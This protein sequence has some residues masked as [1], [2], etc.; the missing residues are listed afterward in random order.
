MFIFG[1]ETEFT[2]YIIK[3]QNE[4]KIKEGNVDLKDKKII[5]TEFDYGTYSN[6]KKNKNSR[7]LSDLVLL[8]NNTI[9]FAE[10]K[11]GRITNEILQLAKQSIKNKFYYKEIKVIL[12]GTLISKKV[13]EEIIETKYLKYIIIDDAEYRHGYKSDIEITNFRYKKNIEAI[14]YTRINKIPFIENN[15]HHL[16]NFYLNEDNTELQFKFKYWFEYGFNLYFSSDSW[17][18]EIIK[19]INKENSII[20][21]VRTEK[22]WSSDSCHA[23]KNIFYLFQNIRENFFENKDID[24]ILDTIDVCSTRN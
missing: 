22:R 6:K 13:R 14:A 10:I 18:I 12:I 2:D 21:N 19:M 5:D 20:L 4:I 16:N 3:N 24:T 1:K 15:I 11:C 17:S 9:W 8:D 7:K 23:I